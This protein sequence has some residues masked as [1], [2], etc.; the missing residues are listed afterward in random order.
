MAVGG[1][2]KVLHGT[3]DGEAV[4]VK[5]YHRTADAKDE[6]R[7]ELSCYEKLGQLL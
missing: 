2:C 7:Q 4:A 3:F 5:I 6:M 1:S